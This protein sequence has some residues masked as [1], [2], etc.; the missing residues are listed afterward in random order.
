[1]ISTSYPIPKDETTRLQIIKEKNSFDNYENNKFLR[2]INKL[3][4]S[5]LNVR[6]SNSSAIYP[7]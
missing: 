6:P 1:M 3:A 4:A 2:E 5:Y 7:L